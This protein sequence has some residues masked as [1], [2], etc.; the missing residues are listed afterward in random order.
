MKKSVVSTLAVLSLSAF[1]LGAMSHGSSPESSNS[2]NSY[3]YFNAVSKIITEELN[4]RFIRDFGEQTFLE[5]KKKFNKNRIFLSDLLIQPDLFLKIDKIKKAYEESNNFFERLKTESFTIKDLCEKVM[6]PVSTAAICQLSEE[7]LYCLYR[8]DKDKILKII[9]K[10]AGLHFLEIFKQI[11]RLLDLKI[12]SDNIEKVL[13][14]VLKRENEVEFK[15]AFIDEICA[16]DI[17]QIQNYIDTQDTLD[18]AT[19]F[20]EIFELEIKGG[21]NEIY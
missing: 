17:Q 14:D 21:L 20:E 16:K 3:K 5:S 10:V 8:V 19:Q 18:T 11:R 1:Q 12:F 7:D 4:A 9:A 2:L 13:R 6:F 15:R